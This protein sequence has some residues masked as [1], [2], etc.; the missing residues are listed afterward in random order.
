MFKSVI[1]PHRPSPQNGDYINNQ[2][3]KTIW[4]VRETARFTCRESYVISGSA[5]SSCLVNGNWS[6]PV[7]QCRRKCKCLE[8]KQSKS[9]QVI[10]VYSI[11]FIKYA[12]RIFLIEY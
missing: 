11:D 9:F 12:N 5:S 6:S 7:P 10:V 2:S 1:C 4:Y 8:R 3:N